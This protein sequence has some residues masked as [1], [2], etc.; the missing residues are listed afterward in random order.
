MA[1]VA[2]AEVRDDVAR[3]LV[4]LGEQ[5]A[6]LVVRVDLGAH[7]LQEVVRLGQVL[8]VRPVAL[9][10]VR[11][12]VEPEAVEPEVEPEAEHV[13]HVPLHVR[14]VVVQIG[15]VREEAVP[16]VLAA[17][18]VPRPVRRLGVEED[19]ARFT[20]ARV[21]VAPNVEV[22]VLARRVGAA[23]LEP[24]VVGARVVHDQV[25][26]HADAAL[27]RLVDEVAEVVDGPVVGIDLVEVGDVVAAV[28]ERR[29]I[30]RQQPDAVDAEPL[31]VVELVGEAAEIAGA[32]VVPVEERA[33]V[34]LVED[35]R[36]E[37]QRLPLEP[38]ACF[39]QAVTFTM[40]APPGGSLT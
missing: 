28:A 30:E 11:D 4:R 7:A 5:H 29:R 31:Q 3:P 19:D 2:V 23:R 8:A 15:L 14:V 17:H 21:V 1:L 38:A 36:L 26:D 6:V 27:V 20:P 13:E 16:E 35:G 9:V 34:D 40:C 39:A 37:P 33:Q 25:G 12:G 22:A 32:V 10:E 18:R 24:R